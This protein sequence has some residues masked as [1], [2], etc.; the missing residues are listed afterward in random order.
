MASLSVL[1]FFAA[2]LLL[3]RLLYGHRRCKNAQDTRRPLADA[4][5]EKPAAPRVQSLTSFD[6][7]TTEPL[8][9]RPF[10][11]VYHMTMGLQAS[12]PEELVTIDSNYLKRV[13]DRR[14][15]IREHPSTVMGFVP[16]GREAVQELYG[17][18][19]A[20]YLPTRYPRM[21]RLSSEG[22]GKMD[23]LVTGVTVPTRCPEDPLQALRILGETV[24]DDLFLLRETEEGHL[25]VAFV[26]CHPSG[27]D[28]ST[29][30][31]KLLKDV[32]EPVPSYEKIGPSME[33]FFSRLE[34]GKNV[35]RLNWSVTTRTDLF[36]PSGTHVYRD[37]T[38]TEDS[39]VDVENA[40]LRVELQTL[41][42]LPQTQAIL[43]S[44]KT[45]LEPLR[46]IKKEGLGPDLAEAIEGLKRGN[47]PGM[48]VYKGGVRWG[49]SICEYLR[50]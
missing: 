11:P 2:F 43:F 29:K 49:R 14:D 40:C 23:N 41:S 48:W 39:E 32:H 33:R 7:E 42:R 37:E 1:Y 34:V 50:A 28:P 22:G 3:A 35:K 31:G 15:V 46:E 4:A 21:F 13:S 30:L 44:F 47:A 8:K 18:L 25:V 12:L 9:F 19:V 10:K 26:C 17:F 6:W 45:Y 24:E 27:F 38:V 20:D 16:A 5:S 36:T